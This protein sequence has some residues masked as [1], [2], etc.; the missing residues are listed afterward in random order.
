[1]KI[2]A[3]K[4]HGNSGK[5]STLLELYNLFNSNPNYIVSCAKQK[6][7]NTTD[8]FAKFTN[9]ITKNQIAIYSEGDIP[10]CTNRAITTF[11][12]L[13]TNDIL[14][15]AC[16]TKGEVLKIL[17][18]YNPIYIRKSTTYYDKKVQKFLNHSDAKIIE[19][20]IQKL[21]F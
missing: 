8:F 9:P 5:T 21:G 11:N 7:R 16:R 10:D 1:M 6:I 3:L 12:D 19:L 4:G 2:I 18:P 13:Q 17:E 20:E 15:L 14:V